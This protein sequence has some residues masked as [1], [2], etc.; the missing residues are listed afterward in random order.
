ME[1]IQYG[2]ET[3]LIRQMESFSLF[4]Q[5]SWSSCSRHR[6]PN[7]AHGKAEK[8]PQEEDASC[9]QAW[10]DSLHVSMCQV[11]CDPIDQR[12]WR[13]AAARDAMKQLITELRARR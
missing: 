5:D 10:R 8:R 4:K 12:I 9:N 2:S 3:L 6:R 1:L 13:F 11:P 7:R